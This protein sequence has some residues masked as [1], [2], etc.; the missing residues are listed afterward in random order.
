MIRLIIHVPTKLVGISMR[1]KSSS[2][3]DYLQNFIMKTATSLSIG[4]ALSQ[5]I[6]IA[7]AFSSLKYALAGKIA[8]WIYCLNSLVK[9]SFLLEIS[10]HHHSICWVKSLKYQTCIPKCITCVVVTIGNHYQKSSGN[11]I[12]R[13]LVARVNKGDSIG[14]GPIISNP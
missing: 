3:K 13:I 12:L 11:R 4:A 5:F 1:T 2:M 7:R 8:V 14:I 6:N 10:H 9:F